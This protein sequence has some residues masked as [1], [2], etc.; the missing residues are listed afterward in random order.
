[1]RSLVVEDDILSRM[2][3]FSILSRYGECD[4]AENG[5]QAVQIVRT[6]LAAGKPYDVICLD[7]I[8]PVLDGHKALLE[9]RKLERTEGVKEHNLMKVIMITA[10]DDFNH[11]VKSFEDG[12]CE[13]YLA[14]PIKEREILEHLHDLELI[15]EA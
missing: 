15:E 14:K 9:I 8:M 7:I 2:L 13:A 1:V 10:V 6:S 12:H 3:L 4:V 11:I 5:E